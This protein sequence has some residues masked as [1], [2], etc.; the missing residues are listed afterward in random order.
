MIATPT[1]VVALQGDPADVLAWRRRGA[2]AGV[3]EAM[4]DA[5]YGLAAKG[6]V[7]PTGTAATLPPPPAVPIRKTVTLW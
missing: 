3:V 1:I 2:T 5:N 6:P 4:L 7:L